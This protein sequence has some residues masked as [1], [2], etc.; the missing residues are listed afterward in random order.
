MRLTH[1]GEMNTCACVSAGPSRWCP[2][3]AD[4]RDWRT[5]EPGPYSPSHIH[6][7]ITQVIIYTTLFTIQS[8]SKQL[9]RDNI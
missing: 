9:Y 7:L 3:A 4:W 2:P 8:V 6:T 5:P 1:D